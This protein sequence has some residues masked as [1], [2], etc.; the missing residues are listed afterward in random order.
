[1][2]NVVITVTSQTIGNAH[3]LSY[4]HR[5]IPY[6]VYRV[7]LYRVTVSGKND[8]NSTVTE[9]FEAIRFG[10]QR[11]LSRSARVV[12][13]A[14]EQTHTLDWSNITTMRG[15]AWRVYDG[16]FIHRGP[17]NPLGA[18]MGSIGCVEICGA[19]EWNRFNDT[20]NV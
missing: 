10:V 15:S 9:D 6:T 5:P 13:L 4:P 1:M 18:E 20:I 14:D 7:P 16:F 12:G 8:K 19:D 2:R 17:D 3:I 11:T